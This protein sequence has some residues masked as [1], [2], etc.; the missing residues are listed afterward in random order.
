LGVVLVSPSL[1]RSRFSDPLNR[2]SRVLLEL[3]E[4]VVNELFRPL[5]VPPDVAVSRLSSV[6]RGLVDEFEEDPSE[7]PKIASTLSN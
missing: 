7:N 5:L 2:F 1:N 4:V 6:L 3:P